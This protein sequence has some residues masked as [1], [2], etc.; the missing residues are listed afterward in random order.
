MITTTDEFF[1]VNK[2]Q[3]ADLTPLHATFLTHGAP[4]KTNFFQT[5]R[6]K[7]IY[8]LK[9][10]TIEMLMHNSRDAFFKLSNN[11]HVNDI[12]WQKA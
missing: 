4:R 11:I 9:I 6:Y 2:F 3:K 8:N 1:K 7:S 10:D 12:Y 5:R